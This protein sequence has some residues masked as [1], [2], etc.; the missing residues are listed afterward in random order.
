MPAFRWTE[1]LAALPMVMRW[2]KGGGEVLFEDTVCVGWFDDD[3]LKHSLSTGM[4]DASLN[5]SGGQKRIRPQA[6]VL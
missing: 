3:K 5:K 6:G 4:T 2:G 1:G